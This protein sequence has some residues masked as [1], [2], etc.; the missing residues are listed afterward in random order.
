MDLVSEVSLEESP[1]ELKAQ[2]PILI[3]LIE[4]RLNDAKLFQKVLATAS[5]AGRYWLI[6]TK[7]L[8][9]ALAMLQKERVDEVLLDLSLPDS[10]GLGSIDLLRS[11]APTVPII[12]LTGADE[13]NVSEASI[14]FGA[15]EFI[16]KNQMNGEILSN[17]IRNSIERQKH[18]NKLLRQH[19]V[20]QQALEFDAETQLPSEGIFRVR[21]DFALEQARRES[22]IIGL[23]LV[24]INRFILDDEAAPEG[25]TSAAWGFLSGKIINSLRKNDSVGRLHSDTL[26]ILCYDLGDLPDVHR[27]VS[28]IAQLLS[29]PFEFQKDKLKVSFNIGV[30]LSPFD[31]HTV[32]GLLA[33]A[34]R[35]LDSSVQLGKNQFCFASKLLNVK[36]TEKAY[37]LEKIKAAISSGGFDV[38]ASQILSK[39]GDPIGFRLNLSAV[40]SDLV[41]LTSLEILELCDLIGARGEI[42]RWLANRASALPRMPLHI[43]FP[44]TFLFHKSFV[45]VVISALVE[46]KIDPSTWVIEIP[47]DAAWARP[48]RASRLFEELSQKGIY[49]SFENLGSA[50]ASLR[51][52]V[53]LRRYNLY[54]VG[55]SLEL[56]RDSMRGSDRLT[57]VEVMTS[58]AHQLGFKVSAKGLN[59][60]QMFDHVRKLGCDYFE[61]AALNATG[62]N[63]PFISP[64]DLVGASV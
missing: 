37:H 17:S 13:A 24:K 1:E 53:H 23:M 58:S 33:S 4:D 47:E 9:S 10:E 16:S 55:I 21:L 2:R 59:D 40:D 38:T 32:D 30:A 45:S 57:L 52:L 61:G 43:Q 34:N 50:Q 62:V 42:I 35:A 39:G 63:R 15:Q 48:E 14:R 5:D 27:L 8:S 26:A 28:K 19:E 11:T 25:L 56:I 7:R 64:S 36:V 18:R 54:S 60:A 22:K 46:N 41:S 44:T 49:F 29:S 51:Q 3:L 12:V 20:D 6:H 31:D